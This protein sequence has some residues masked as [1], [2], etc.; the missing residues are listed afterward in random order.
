MSKTT[1]PKPKNNIASATE[2]EDIVAFHGADDLFSDFDLDDIDPEEAGAMFSMMNEILAE[3]RTA[4]LKLTE[5]VLTHSSDP[6]RSAADIFT[7]F[8]QAL[9]TV[10]GSKQAR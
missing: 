2:A 9:D 7:I 10:A 8:H 5:L 6:K 3:E 4:A 1:K